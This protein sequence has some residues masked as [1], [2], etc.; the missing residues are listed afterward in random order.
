MH[1]ESDLRAEVLERQRLQAADHW[2]DFATIVASGNLGA[3]VLAAGRV[4][5]AHASTAGKAILI[6]ALVVSVE[7][8]TLAYLSLAVGRTAVVGP[9]HLLDVV[10]AFG[11]AAAQF[12]MPAWI[13]HVAGNGAVIS[14][15]VLVSELRHWFAFAGCF[16]AFASAANVAAQRRRAR[17]TPSARWLTTLDEHQRQDR[18]HAT[19]LAVGASTGW[20]LSLLIG[21]RVPAWTSCALIVGLMLSALAFG[22]GI[23]SQ[24]VTIHDLET[25]LAGVGGTE[26]RRCEEDDP[27]R[28]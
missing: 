4:L 23:R 7:A 20:V 28:S 22:L 12:A 15:Q 10:V 26:T 18:K 16:A 2:K 14:L 9:V 21:R 5:S 24:T 25:M 19:A 1:S 8:F 13:A 11:I 3:S 27:P 6:L 17:V